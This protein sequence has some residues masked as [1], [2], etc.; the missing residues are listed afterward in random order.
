MNN[1]HHKQMTCRLT[2]STIT[3]IRYL[4]D[5]SSQARKIVQWNFIEPILREARNL[6]VYATDLLDG[7][8]TGDKALRCIYNIQKQSI[9]VCALERDNRKHKTE[10]NEEYDKRKKQYGF[11]EYACAY[12]DEMCDD[13]IEQISAYCQNHKPQN[14]G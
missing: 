8:D 9:L 2:T 12:I 3:L 10:L 6:F 4:V 11:D 5:K 1:R 13:I 14:K 7:R